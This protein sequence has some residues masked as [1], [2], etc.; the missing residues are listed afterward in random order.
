MHRPALLTLLAASLPSFVAAQQATVAEPPAASAPAVVKSLRPQPRGDE[1]WRDRHKQ[2]LAEKAQAEAEGRSLSLVFLGDS[3]THGWEDAGKGLWAERFAPHGALNLG[4]SGDR[5]EHL[6]W[7]LGKGDAGEANNEVAGLAPKA[8]FVMIGTNNTGHNKTNPDDTAAGITAIVDRLQE[9]SPGSEIVLQAVFPRGEKPDDPL[10][11]INDAV[12]ERIAR[13]GERDGLT[14]VDLSDAFLDDD[15]TLP[16]SVMPD[17]LHPS[18]EGY[19]RWA[20]A[21]QPHVDRIVG[22]EE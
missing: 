7:R 1:W 9:L 10:R 2:K 15:G 16:K 13:L 20:E 18:E 8:F 14:F 5:T 21:I 19:R 11:K 12:N 22:A 3:I 6:L 17:L 4:F